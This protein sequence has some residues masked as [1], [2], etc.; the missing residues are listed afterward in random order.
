M[1][2]EQADADL[3]N[4][5]AAVAAGLDEV[6][7]A[8]LDPADSPEAIDLIDKLETLG[9][10][11]DAARVGLVDVI[12]RKGLYRADGHHSAKIMVRH[13]A[14]LSGAEA[15]ARAKTARAL[16]DLP[17]TRAAFRAGEV[18]SCQVRRMARAHANPRVR[19][20]LPE[21]EG[22]LLRIATAE[23]FKVFDEVVGDWVRLADED[24]TCDR[25]QRRHEHRD[26]RP[27]RDFD[28]GWSYEG[29]CGSLA[30]VE[31]KT[32]F[33]HFVEAEFR[34]DWDKANIEHGDATTKEHLD[35]TDAQRRFD[36]FYAMCL[37]AASTEPGGKTPEIV[38]NLV[39]DHTTYERTLE[40]L[41]TGIRPPADPDDPGYR[42]STI[43]GHPVEPTEAV[44]ASLTGRLRRVVI[45]ADGVVIDLGR[46]VRLF[47]GLARLAAQLANTECF[48]PGCHVP[49]SQCQI[50][51]LVPFT[52][53]DDGGGGGRTSPDNGGPACGKHNRHKE[54]GFTV[55]RDTD[56]RWHTLRPDGTEIE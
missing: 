43:D 52:E 12:D 44:A 21:F 4:G 11:L 23:S 26:F 15:A 20:R 31:V 5:L 55:W 6:L 10:R 3:G 54:S 39:I 28:G 19:D 40:A 29:G 8:G 41:I 2:I 17:E 27:G 34:T 33:D 56:G 37:R 35:R 42:C 38:T 51:H 18:G 16:R 25:N 1:A 49:V 7:A 13:V 46:S 30:G 47:T 14:K 32:I 48:W 36:A 45:G 24:G 50:D 53:R 22:P 9:R